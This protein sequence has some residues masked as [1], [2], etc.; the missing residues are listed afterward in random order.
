MTPMPA[1]A[2]EP[3][4]PVGDAK[5]VSKRLT[6]FSVGKPLFDFAHLIFSQLGLVVGY[7]FQATSALCAIVNVALACVPAKVMLVD[8]R[9]VVAGMAGH[10]LRGWRLTMSAA[11]NFAMRW[12]TFSLNSHLAVTGFASVKRPFNAFIG[13]RFGKS[14][15]NDLFAYAQSSYDWRSIKVWTFALKSRIMIGAQS[16]R[17]A[18][19]AAIINRANVAGPLSKSA[20]WGAIKR[21]SVL[22]PSPVMP[23]AK[24]A[25]FDVRSAAMN[26]ANVAH[27]LPQMFG[28]QHTIRGA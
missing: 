17:A 7:A 6:G 20:N 14:F 18:R 26:C 4:C 24:A 2:D 27:Y 25:P 15:S 23:V 1:L 13:H 21:I 28:I 19:R 22:P 16:S 12:R 9:G 10:V 11:T 3:N 8:A 5:L